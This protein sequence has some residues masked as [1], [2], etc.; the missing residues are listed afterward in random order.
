MSAIFPELPFNTRTMSCLL[1]IE[2]DID[3]GIE[4]KEIEKDIEKERKR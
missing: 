2:K 1:E 4:K 3:K